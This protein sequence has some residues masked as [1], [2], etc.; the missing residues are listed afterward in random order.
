MED[1]APREPWREGARWWSLGLGIAL[2]A[3]AVPEWLGSRGVAAPS[4]GLGGACVA[5]GAAPLPYVWRALVMLVVAI[6][7]LLLG[8][9]DL[10]PAAALS[11]A[12]GEWGLVHGIAAVGLPAALLFRE[13]YRAYAGAR[14]VLASALVLAI[15]FVGYSILRVF[16]QTGLAQIASGA[17]LG[18]VCLSLFGFMGSN[19]GVAGKYLGSLVITGVT[20]QLAGEV[21]ARTIPTAALW[22]SHPPPV[23]DLVGIGAFVCAALLGA[24]GAAQLLA[25]RSWAQARAV[26]VR[27][28]TDRP[29]MPSVGSDSWS[30]G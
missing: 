3:S 11:G 14:Y 2:A 1:I 20:L 22:P 25:A 19:T 30:G 29:P 10:G 16:D 13:R 17:A 12:V 21:V 9:L 8:I 18:S 15:P 5:A 24:L 23:G 4:L 27:Q 28:T 26:D 6:A 7:T